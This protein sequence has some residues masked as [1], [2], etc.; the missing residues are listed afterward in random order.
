M[1]ERPLPERTALVRSLSGRVDE[2]CRTTR[3]KAAMVTAEMLG[4]WA[5]QPRRLFTSRC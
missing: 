2:F 3:L 1:A 5:A 4:E